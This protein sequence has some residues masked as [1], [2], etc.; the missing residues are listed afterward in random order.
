MKQFDYNK[1]L[2]N[3]PLLKEGPDK[4]A[5]KVLNFTTNQE[6]EEWQKNNVPAVG[7]PIYVAGKRVFYSWEKNYKGADK[8]SPLHPANSA[9]SQIQRK[10]RGP[11]SG[12]AEAQ[13]E[14]EEAQS[15]ESTD[16]YVYYVQKGLK[17]GEFAYIT[18]KTK[19]V[20]GNQVVTKY[21][22]QFGEIVKIV[23]DKYIVAD[24]AWGDK[25]QNSRKNLEKY[26]L[27][28]KK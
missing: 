15:A 10:S 28:V 23:G 13:K 9:L 27:I 4:N 7:Q 25:S 8:K 20:V 11:I 18:A 12:F 26:Y 14:V 21:S 2:K 19:V 24:D 5:N 3:N 16:D 6:W 17:K 1:Y 22:G